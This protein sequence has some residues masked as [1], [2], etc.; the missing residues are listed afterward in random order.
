MI[1]K[2]LLGLFIL[3]LLPLFAF[4]QSQQNVSIS[5]S[6]TVAGTVEMITINTVDFDDIEQEGSEIRV[7]PIF[8]ERSGKMVAR[9]TPNAEFRVDYIRQRELVNL[10]GEGIIF[11]NYE[12]AGNGIDDQE[13]AELLDQD[14]RDLQFNE[15]GEFYFWIG[16]T[17]DLSDVNPGSYQGEFTIEIEYI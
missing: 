17:I 2:R 10:D 8:G 1:Y 16:G 12:V 11:F 7:D 5:V 9:G 15:E 3:A 14:I 13:T 6:A 4:A